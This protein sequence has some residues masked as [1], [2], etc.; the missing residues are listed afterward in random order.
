MT[1]ITQNKMTTTIIIPNSYYFNKKISNEELERN[2]HRNMVGGLFEEFGELQ[3]NLC[4]KY[5]MTPNTKLLDFGC[6]CL[7]GGVR[8]IDFLN[9]G[10]Y[11]GID[12]NQ[13]LLESGLFYE[14]PKHNISQKIVQN[15]FLISDNF[16]IDFF[17][18]KFDIILA[19]SVF[20][21]LTL[22]HFLFFMEKCYDY[23]EENGKIIISFWLLE[24]YE[25]IIKPKF[26]IC[27]DMTMET[28]FIRDSYHYKLSH[29]EKLVN[30]KWKIT[31]LDD[32]HPRNQKF[33]IFTKKVN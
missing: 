29:L 26:F 18:V 19:Q 2:L 25:D 21:H 15:N 33:L 14:I 16:D 17:Q 22:N 4:K 10:N 11:Y 27:D 23:I 1:P 8:L 32:Y 9:K 5:G 3:L 20:T 7:R 30:D 24:E 31:Q 28:S 13:E 12:V 6:G